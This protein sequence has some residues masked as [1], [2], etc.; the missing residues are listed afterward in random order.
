MESNV[1]DDSIQ[2]EMSWKTINK[3]HECQEK[4]E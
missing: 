1:F 4:G 2:G 3:S